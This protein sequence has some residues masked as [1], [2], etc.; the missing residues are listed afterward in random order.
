MSQKVS[1]HLYH[2]C[3]PIPAP[4]SV[5]EQKFEAKEEEYVLMVS[6]KVVICS[7]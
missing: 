1:A 2:M 4:K 5:R 3:L 7:S 6:V